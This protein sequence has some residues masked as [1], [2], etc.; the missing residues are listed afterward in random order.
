MSCDRIRLAN[1]ELFFDGQG[2]LLS[3]SSNGE[4]VSGEHL[5]DQFDV[6]KRWLPAPLT[7]ASPIQASGG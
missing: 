1:T 5:G 6:S 7:G 3:G 4:P 2:E